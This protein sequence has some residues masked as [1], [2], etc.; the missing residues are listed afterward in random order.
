M[1]RRKSLIVAFSSLI[2]ASVISIGA[3]LSWFV[4][5]T[6]IGNT[7]STKTM[8]IDGS[9]GSSYF[10]Y[11]NG[12]PEGSNPSDKPYGITQPR[13]LYNLAW[14]QYLGLFDQAD[15]AKQN[16]G[17]QYYFELA[18]DINMTGWVLPPIGT[19]DH[20]FIGNFNGNGYT[21]SNLTVSNSFADYNTH[22]DVITE[23]NDSGANKTPHILGLFGVVGNYGN[24][25]N[26]EAT[27]CVFSSIVNEFKDTGVTAIT[28]KTSVQDSLMGLVAGYVSGNM[29]NIAVDSGTLNVI[30]DDSTYYAKPNE[31]SPYTKN[32]SDYGLVGYTT[33]KSSITKITDTIFDLNI[34]ANQEFTAYTQGGSQGWGGSVDMNAVYDRIKGILPSSTSQYDWKLTYNDVGGVTDTNPTSDSQKQA[35]YRSLRNYNDDEIAS[36]TDDDTLPSYGGCFNSGW[37]PGD[38]HYLLGGTYQIHNRFNAPVADG[39]QISDGNGHYLSFDGSE[40]VDSSYHKAFAWEFETNNG[41]GYIRTKYNNNYYYLMKTAS[42]SLAIQQVTE[43]N[44]TDWTITNTTSYMDI[45]VSSGTTTYCLIYSDGSWSLVDS[46]TNSSYYD[47]SPSSSGGNYIPSS[48]IGH[49][50]A[51][52]LNPVSTSELSFNAPSNGQQ[53]RFVYKGV[54]YYLCIY[55]GG[56]NGNTVYLTTRTAAGSSGNVYPLVYYTGGYVRTSSMYRINNTRNRYG[57]LRY[58]SN[59]WTYGS[60]GNTDA[61]AV[62][63]VRKKIGDLHLLV[64]KTE[65]ME[66]SSGDTTYFPI[67]A[68]TG[69]TRDKSNKL[70]G[71]QYD[72]E[73]TNSGYFV[74]GSTSDT[75]ADDRN[76]PRN[77]IVSQYNISERITRSYD[78][79]NDKFIDSEIYTIDGPYD[80]NNL[81]NGVHPV[82]TT[83]TVKYSK[84]AKTKKMMEDNLKGKTKVGGFHFFA[85]K[86]EY[87]VSKDYVLNAKNIRFRGDEYSQFEL[88]VYSLDFYLQEQGRVNFFAGLY[89]GSNDSGDNHMNGFFS[90]HKVIRD[91]ETNKITDIKEIKCIY[92]DS[93]AGEYG[94]YKYTFRVN[95]SI[96]DE[97]GNEFDED[98]IPPTYTL[99]F[100]T[101]WIGHR[102]NLGRATNSNNVNNVQRV[103]YFE[104]P[105]DQGEYCFGGF[106][107]RHKLPNGTMETGAD[108]AYLMYLDIGAGA[109]K[110]QRTSVAEHFLEGVYVLSYPTGVALIPLNT[111]G[112]ENYKNSNSVCFIVKPSYK[113]EV[114]VNRDGSNNVEIKR[115][116][117]TSSFVKPS[118]VSNEIASVVDPGPL[119]ATTDDYDFLEENDILYSSKVITETFRVQYFDYNVKYN[120][121]T[122]TIIS[123]V[124]TNT[125]DAGWSNINRTITQQTFDLT[126]GTQSAIVTLTSETQVTDGTIQVFKYFAE[127]SNYAS[128]TTDMSVYNG[129]AYSYAELTSSTTY[130]YYSLS[131]TDIVTLQS[132]STACSCLDDE[133]LEMYAIYS[134]LA[135]TNVTIT[136]TI[137]LEMVKDTTI[138]TGY[139]YKYGDYVFTPVVVGSS[140]N[141]IVTTADNDRPVYFLTS[142]EDGTILVVRTNP[143][144][145]TP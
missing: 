141:Y 136:T 11:G 111:L 82:D 85:S 89:N 45:R 38:R 108:G 123:D 36:V 10:A 131:S 68:Y 58:N 110:T 134:I 100:D 106:E 39:Y 115:A 17:V 70:L 14:L 52:A 145:V 132:T 63:F 116:T 23:F 96:I 105:L 22:P 5:S 124:R 4:P 109:A 104:I 86:A 7:G 3:S 102:P 53:V 122:K 30:P 43:A 34:R 8:P 99:L 44:A 139:Y 120:T 57:Y 19:E 65:G 93:T 18:N 76:G 48:I 13:H 16:Y 42:N 32:I 113:G 66:F 35:V 37:E 55:I 41:T 142:G 78:D 121:M 84:Y 1:N 97:A 40:L 95:D 27:T 103:F 64:N 62:S 50:S 128:D 129:D 56:T 29:S 77:I 91:E 94:R 92:K 81:S 28:V 133:I 73:V 126:A 90:L 33:S 140:I 12:H 49:N 26:T 87:S 130:F 144:T 118:Y 21:I 88:P 47:I 2:V 75:W 54:T 24:K 51:G 31:T 46:Q 83:D 137:T 127:S 61:Y 69:E 135:G 117:S 20:P 80:P 107:L 79:E 74:A 138:T 6:T 101:E 119:E 72:A 114:S 25:Y 98:S 59:T 15:P 67:S 71:K 60:S 143:Y 112:T 9:S 125:D